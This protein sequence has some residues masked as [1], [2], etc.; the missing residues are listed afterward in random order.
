MFTTVLPKREAGHDTLP[1]CLGREN[2]NRLVSLWDIVE[3]FDCFRYT[4]FVSNLHTLETAVQHLADRGTA[5][6]VERMVNERS[7]TSV[8]P[9]DIRV[10]LAEMYSLENEW[11]T[12]MLE[13]QTKTLEDLEAY[14]NTAGFKNAAV[15]ARLVRRNLECKPEAA[16]I[17]VELYHARAA[18][19]FD[20]ARFVFLH[21]QDDRR[22]FIDNEELFGPEVNVAFPSAERDIREGGNCLA[23][24]AGTAAVFH[25]M[26][27]VEIAL[28]SLAADRRVT[29]AKGSLDAKQWGELIDAVERKVG[30]L[31]KTDSKLWISSDVKDAQ[32]RFYHDAMIEFRSF[33]EAFRRHVSHADSTAFYDRDQAL[34]VKNHSGAFMHKLAS[35]IVEFSVGPEFW[36]T[37]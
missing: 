37:I 9:E 6:S 26:R 22:E 32:V 3:R 16:A 33:N 34:S 35:K 1:V 5:A 36:A 14:A 12:P 15:T 8:I 24:E 18:L 17:A 7:G 19:V 23:S 21:I 30:D 11:M 29:F 20:A 28:R 13:L 2:P 31:R 4:M 10:R 25:F 27:A